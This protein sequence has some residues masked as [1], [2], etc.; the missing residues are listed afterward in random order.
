MSH[1]GLVMTAKEFALTPGT[2]PPFTRSVHLGPVNYTLPT[3]CTTIQQ[4]TK[5]S[6]ANEHLLHLF[7]IEQMIETQMKA[8]VLSCFDKDI[9]VGLKQPR[10]GYTN[11]T[12]VRVFEYLYTKYGEKTE[13]LQN[14]PLDNLDEEENIT[15][16]SIKPFCLKQGKLKIFLQNT[17]QAI[18]DGMYIKTCLRVIEKIQLHQQ[19][20]PYVASTTTC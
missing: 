14:K 7:E 4:H 9:Y 11:I 20:R 15:G 16:P 10:I 2:T 17:E 8:H 12:T 3:A 18:S 5:R 1:I 19:K 13:E 6:L